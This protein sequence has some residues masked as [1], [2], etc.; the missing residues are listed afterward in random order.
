MI[1]KI[2]SGI[3]TWDITRIVAKYIH[4]HFHEKKYGL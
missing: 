2:A 3:V 4:T 1:E